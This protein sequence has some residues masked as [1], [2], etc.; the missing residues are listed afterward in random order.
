M[1]KSVIIPTYWSRRKS[2][3]WQKG[4]AVYDHPTP[5]DEK[6]TLGRTLESMKLLD[7]R[8]FK[9]VILI[10]PT[11]PEV[12]QEA[13]KQ[14]LSIVRQVGLNAETYLFTAGDLRDMVEIFAANE[15]S[16][17]SK[18]LLTMRGYPNVRNMCLLA[19]S[20]LSS[21]VTLLIDDDEVFENSDFLTRATEFIGKR[22]YGDVIHGIAGYY[23]NKNGKYYDDVKPEAWTTYW[24]RF[25]A[26]AKAFDKIIG[27]SPRIK[28][29]PF[30]FGGA[31]VI[32]RELF[33]C[34]PFDPKVTR[35]ED[36]D[37]LINSNMYGFSFFLDNTLPI[38]H[39]PEPKAHPKWMQLREDIY[40]FVYQKEKMNAQHKIGNMVMVSPEDFDPYP[41][42]FL[43]DD[44]EDKI[45]KSSLMLATQYMAEGDMS[46]CQEA[47]QNIY[48][49]KHDAPPKFNAFDS[50]RNAQKHWDSIIKS[51]RKNRYALRAILE[52]HNLSGSE[53][54]R[55][56]EHIRQMTENEILKEI[57][58]IPLFDTITEDEMSIL[59]KVCQIKTYYDK[60]VIFSA[61][62][63]IDAAHVVLKG[64]IRLSIYNDKDPDIAPVIVANLEK[65]DL[66]GES[67]L[68]YNT[69]RINGMALEFTEL[70]FIRK[71]DLNN[72]IEQ[73]PALGTKILKL[74][75]SGSAA[76]MNRSN[77]KL[78]ETAL[79]NC[80]LVDP[81]IFD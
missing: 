38:K 15:L 49:A 2:D 64:R 55:D 70:L 81:S 41:G 23:L 52:H 50:Y 78:K 9:L 34:V 68:V 8:D 39:L 7:E 53:V 44:L 31:M 28:R 27:S 42:E 66:L 6:G 57:E 14:V 75:L 30:A 62:D 11:T 5:V 29:T 59:S 63:F 43:K 32:H 4:D 67:C 22:V 80:N 10:C 25:G 13:Y 74:L 60:E 71:T 72:M 1:R 73:Y 45:F 77:E 37:Y 47:L 18:K 54:I 12:E 36:V 48:I 24:D 46:A 65:G 26:K 51:V 20:I 61:G 69:Y 3:P 17:E 79:Y 35:G 58:K 19:A 56:K 33:E 40:R 21:D 16:D 76:K